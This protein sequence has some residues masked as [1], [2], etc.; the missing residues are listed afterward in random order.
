MQI[1]HIKN[2]QNPSKDVL[3]PRV[4]WWAGFQLRLIALPLYLQF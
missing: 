2:Q 4:A 1:K 3:V